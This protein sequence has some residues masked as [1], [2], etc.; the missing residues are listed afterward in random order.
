MKIKNILY[1]Y[2]RQILVAR[3]LDTSG[4]ASAVVS[5][6]RDA[7]AA[8]P[9]PAGASTHL[10]QE[11]FNNSLAGVYFCIP[12]PLCLRWIIVACCVCC[13]SHNNAICN[14]LYDIYIYSSSQLMCH[15]RRVE[16]RVSCIR[17][18]YL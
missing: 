6:R 13:N 5:P 14:A 8:R 15:T 7:R 16:T 18:A 11:Q 4:A 2:R 10:H 9:V 3:P 1:A 17:I 12:V